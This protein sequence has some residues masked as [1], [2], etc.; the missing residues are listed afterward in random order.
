MEGFWCVFY[1][2]LVILFLIFI[3]LNKVVMFTELKCVKRF[4]S[5]KSTSVTNECTPHLCYC[6]KCS[7]LKIFYSENLLLTIWLENNERK[8]PVFQK[9]FI[10]NSFKNTNAVGF[11][12]ERRMSWHRSTWVR[13]S[14]ESFQ[15]WEGAN[16]VYICGCGLSFFWNSSAWNGFGLSFSGYTVVHSQKKKNW[17]TVLLFW[18]FICAC[19]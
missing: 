15:K 8:Q 6:W 5:L 14:T 10:L 9:L 3:F 13:N 12:P 7:G 19:I 4:Q 1:F 16:R 17:E 11:H 18:V 2:I